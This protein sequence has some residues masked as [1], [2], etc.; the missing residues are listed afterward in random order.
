MLL[1]RRFVARGPAFRAVAPGPTLLTVSPCYFSRTERDLAVFSKFRWSITTYLHAGHGSP[2]NPRLHAYYSSTVAAMTDA[3]AN[4]IA[5]GSAR[6]KLPEGVF[7]N[8][9]QEFNR[10]LTVAVLQWFQKVHKK[11]WLMKNEKR[12]NSPSRLSQSQY[13]GL[14]ILEALGGSGIRSVRFALEVPNIGE[15]VCND[16]DERA[17]EMIHQNVLLNG[18]NKFVKVSNLDAVNLMHVY[19]E[20]SSRSAFLNAGYRISASH[21]ERSSFKTNAPM[22]FIWDVFRT[23]R[24]RLQDAEKISSDSSD[25]DTASDTCVENGSAVAPLEKDS[26]MKRRRLKRRNSS[27]DG[28][29]LVTLRGRVRTA[30]LAQ[31]ISGT[32]DFSI[33]PDANP[34]SRVDKLVRFQLNP[35]KFWGPKARP[36]YMKSSVSTN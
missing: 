14:R 25:N 3:V 2:R 22:S 7:Y 19:K 34:P 16:L 10:D 36:K 13:S 8:R 27:T 30:L 18:V 6:I 26:P 35:E 9:V 33:H 11:E 28:T 15:I 23:F 29:D 12:L 31:P 5:E 4:V 32:V 1:F 17:V 20:F 24:Q 21:A